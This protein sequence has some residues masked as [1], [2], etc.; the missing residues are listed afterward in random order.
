MGAQDF[1][2]VLELRG[3]VAVPPGAEGKDLFDRV[4]VAAMVANQGELDKLTDMYMV[5]W[6][7]MPVAPRT[8]L[9]GEGGGMRARGGIMANRGGGQRVHSTIEYVGV[10]GRVRLVVA[11][12]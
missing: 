2:S 8:R 3:T 4:K 1:E 10:V 7:D 5:K 12:G 6:E 11:V 9:A